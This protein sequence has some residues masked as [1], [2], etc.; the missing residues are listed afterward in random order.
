M[1]DYKSLA[2]VRWE[3][4]IHIVW[5]PKY[6]RKKLYGKVRRRFGEITRDLCR[7]KGVELIEGHAKSDHAHLLLKF[8][9]QAQYSLCY[10][11]SEGKKRHSIASRFSQQ[12]KGFKA[13]L[14]TRLL[15]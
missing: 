7:Q 1:R 15:C 14:D 12:R 11:L 9:I 4:K 13:F 8:S 2:H 3:C 10:G 5:V 6:R